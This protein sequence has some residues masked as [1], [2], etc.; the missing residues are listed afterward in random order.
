MDEELKSRLTSGQ[1]WLRG[2]F[3]LLFGLLWGVAEIVLA[4]VVLLQ[5]FYLLFTGGKNERLL[6]FGDAMALYFAQLGQYVTFNSDTKPFP[7]EAWP[8][9]KNLQE[10]EEKPES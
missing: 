7:F 10:A 6:E 4:A 9:P 2:A 3:I 5:F 8:D 1:I